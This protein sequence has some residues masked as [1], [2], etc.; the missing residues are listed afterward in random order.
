M[1]HNMYKGYKN[2]H[3]FN[4]ANWASNDEICNIYQKYVWE[5]EKKNKNNKNIK[6]DM[7]ARGVERKRRRLMYIACVWIS[8]K[9]RLE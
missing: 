9:M 7:C 5:R 3:A 1:R 4:T 8:I 6:W 2:T